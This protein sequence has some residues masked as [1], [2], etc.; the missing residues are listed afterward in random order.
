ME[1]PRT[2]LG[3]RMHGVALTLE[4]NHPPL[5]AYAAE[6]LNGLVETPAAAPDLKVKCYWSEGD[7]EAEANPFPDD[8]VMNVIGKRMLGNAD[9]LIWL[10]TLRMKGL[11]LRFRREH[12]QWT[13]EVA[14]RFHAK[15]EKIENL[16]EPALP[17]A[18]LEALAGRA[19]ALG[20]PGYEYKRYF[21]LMSYLVY[22]P[23]IWYLENSRGWTVLHASALAG[24]Y[25]GIMIGG[26]G[27]VG[28]T[29]TCVALMQRD[30][31]K[32][33]AENIIF[34]DGEFIYPCY[35]PIRLDEG[36]LAM[37]G[38][39][40][41]NGLIPMAFPE[42]LKDKWLFHIKTNTLPEKIKP[43]LLFLPQFSRRRYLTQ[44]APELAAE[45]M[46]AMNHLTRE[47]DDYAWYAA[48]LDMHWPKVGQARHRIEVLRRFA[49]QAYCFEL[50]I[51]RTAGV[52]AVVNDI[53]GTA[54]SL[55]FML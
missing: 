32:L 48:A 55:E 35:E 6:H 42:G 50:G 9:E 22:Y 10:D 41:P 11:Q 51:D 18:R 5:L 20:R 43:A 27:G 13:F 36:S 1:T 29:T 21:S 12:W 15:K 25:G 4:T 31:I 46:V 30:D 17:L 38:K 49:E 54:H 23:L 24:A 44:I 26:L 7:G 33:M 16:P 37:L 34:T 53:L 47:L 28:K 39:D 3:V 2:K 14:Y 19:K 40:N 8:G 45:K 52:E